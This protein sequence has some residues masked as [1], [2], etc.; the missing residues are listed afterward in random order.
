MP[1]PKSNKAT[2]KR[3][4]VQSITCLACGGIK[5]P[6]DFYSS[7]SVNHA[8]T[9]R[10]QYCK[11]CVKS[12]S[13]DKKGIIDLEKLKA[14]L[15]EIDKPFIS[16]VLQSAYNET[17]NGSGTDVIGT[18]FKNICSLPQFK[19][20][21]W[22]NSIFE[23][24]NIEES[25]NEFEVTGA[26]INKWGAGYKPEEYQ[27]FERKYELLKNNYPEKTS[28]HTEA[29]LKYIRYSVKEEIATAT[30]D[31]GAAKSWGQLAKDAATAAKINPS[32]L[33]AADLQDGLS[34][35][36]QL[37]RA[38]EQAIDIIPLLPHFKEKPQDKVDFTMWCYIN[39]VRDLK[40]LPLC[41]YKEIWKFYEDRKKEHENRFDFLNEKDAL[42][43]DG[44]E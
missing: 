27:A 3:V 37:A 12:K 43:E 18:Y 33:S 10:V 28:M 7:R 42:L 11:E 17:N 21:T 20:L 41:E 9:G 24:N 32:Q 38:V 13:T 44:E 36:G 23:E 29:L 16:E 1:R 6:T 4:E 31:V 35:F 19:D 39:Y 26:I 2:R 40:G 30:N 34:T 5:K 25:V 15:R 14:T 22:S 8:G